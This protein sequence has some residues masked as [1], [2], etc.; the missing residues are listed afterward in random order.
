MEHRLQA[1]SFSSFGVWAQKLQLTGFRVQTHYLRHMGSAA[2]QHVGSSQT[3]D[4]TQCSVP[5]IARQILN[6]WTTRE[7]PT[8]VIF[9]FFFILNT[10]MKSMKWCLTEVLICISL[11]TDNTGQL[12]CAC[13]HSCTLFAEMFVQV[14]DPFFW[15]YYITYRIVVSR[16]GVKLAP[17]AVEE[18]SANYWSVREVPF[19]CF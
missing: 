4:Q 5:C 18:C 17:P 7:T 6:H 15:L 13:G 2:P 19:A 11:M 1:H 10:I 9:C 12:T 14:F 16:I 3:S 8:F